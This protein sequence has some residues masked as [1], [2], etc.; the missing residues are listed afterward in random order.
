MTVVGFNFNKI[1]VE[2]TK[3]LQGKVSINNNIAIKDVENKDLSLGAAKQMG[4]K[5]GFEYEVKY[6]N[7]A[8]ENLAHIGLAGEVLILE[9]DSKVKELLKEWEKSKKLNKEV[10]LQ[11]INTAHA[12]CNV[13]AIILSRDIN[14]PSP[15][16]LPKVEAGE[17]APA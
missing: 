15:I 13:Q 1:D 11:V 5:V 17:K 9:Q 2:R 8:K 14:L 3:L 12:K 10:T 16:P 4:L 7:E 6:T